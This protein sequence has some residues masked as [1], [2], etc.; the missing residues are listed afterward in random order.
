MATR[1]H[2]H[3]F[4]PTNPQLAER[5]T[6]VRTARIVMGTL[7]DELT[8]KHRLLSQKDEP[9]CHREEQMLMETIRNTILSFHPNGS[10]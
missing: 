10:R 9:R 3:A 8:L 4:N 2:V 6:H 1:G 7:R 5:V